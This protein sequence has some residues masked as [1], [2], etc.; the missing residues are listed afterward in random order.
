MIRI[1]RRIEGPEDIGDSI[2]P[3]EKPPKSRDKDNYPKRPYP[4][5]DTVEISKAGKEA[6]KRARDKNSK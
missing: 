4:D 2:S 1:G 6:S 3:V 5:T